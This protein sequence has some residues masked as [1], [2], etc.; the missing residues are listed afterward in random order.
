MTLLWHDLRVLWHGLW[1]SYQHLWLRW[2]LNRVWYH[3]CLV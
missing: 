1:L 3:M 2:Y